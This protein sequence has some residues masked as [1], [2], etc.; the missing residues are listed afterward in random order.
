MP[1]SPRKHGY[2][3]SHRFS[4]RGSFEPVLRQPRKMKGDL[5]V[6]H[7]MP[8]ASG[9]S[10]L[11]V[12]LTRRLVPA[13]VERNRVKRI[14]R[15]SFRRHAVKAAGYDCVVALRARFEPSSGEALRAEVERLF[16]RLV[17]V[18]RA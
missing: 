11:G 2:S 14:V 5:V 17:A 1:R 16:T 13:A 8:A 15:E 6:L 7:A 3:R 10:R 9:I 4:T 18:P 12:A